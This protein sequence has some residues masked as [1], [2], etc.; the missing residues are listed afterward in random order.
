MEWINQIE[1]LKAEY[2]RI[3]SEINRTPSVIDIFENSIYPFNIYRSKF[4]SYLSFRKIIDDLTE[5]EKSWFKECKIIS[6]FL[7]QIEKTSMTKSYKIPVIMSLINNNLTQKETTS[8][9]IAQ[10]FKDF[11]SQN[12][13]YQKDLNNKSNKNWRE[14]EL[15][16]FEN[17]ALRNPIKFLSQG[18]MKTFLTMKKIPKYF[19]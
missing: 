3:K 14:W 10:N 4:G 15:S 13:R 17:L 5:L 16:D 12:K 9:E 18:A 7:A 11:Y 19:L 2:L 1:R 8:I 6:K